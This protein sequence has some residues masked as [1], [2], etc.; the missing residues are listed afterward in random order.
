MISTVVVKLMNIA[1]IFQKDSAL[2]SNDISAFFFKK[3]KKKG[4]VILTK[5]WVK[6]SVILALT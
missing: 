2:L 5:A 4:Q 6:G 1:S 3:K